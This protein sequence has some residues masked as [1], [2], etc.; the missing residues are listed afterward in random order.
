MSKET[1]DQTIT[2]FDELEQVL[3]KARQE[4][5]R[6]LALADYFFN[7]DERERFA[8]EHRFLVKV[9]LREHLFL[10]SQ[11]TSLLLLNLN[12][13]DI[14]DTG[15]GTISKLT[16]L[17]SLDLA[18]NKIGDAGTEELSKL[19]N[20]YILDLANNQIRDTG[21]ETISQLT[22]LSF[23]NLANNKIGDTGAEA[24]SKL[25]NLASLYL[26]SNQIGKDGAVALSRLSNLTSLRIDRNQIGKDGAIALSKLTNLISLGISINKIGND[27]I[28]ALSNL[29]G[30][31]SLFT[32]FN[33]I[34]NDGAIALSK[35]SNL[36][37]LDLRV[38]EIGDEGA[39]ALSKLGNLGIVDL[40]ANPI[41]NEGMQ[42][43]F[44]ALLDSDTQV[45][46]RV[47]MLGGN[48]NSPDFLTPEI[49]ESNGAQSILAAYRSYR[50]AKKKGQLKPLNEVKLL[51]VGNEAVGKTSLVRA[52]VEGKVCNDGEPTT[53]GI[54]HQK[55]ETKQWKEDSGITI[56]IWD[57]GGQEVMHGTHRFFLTSRSIYLVVLSDRLHDDRSVNDWLRTIQSRVGD[58]P[59]IVVINK[60]DQE[61][62]GLYLNESGLRKNFPSIIGFI[63]TSCIQDK[64]DTIEPLKQVIIRTIQQDERLKDIRNPLPDSWMQVKNSLV[65]KAKQ[66]KIL[67]NDEFNELCRQ[68]GTITDD[69]EQRAL[70]GLLHDLGVIVIYDE[71][72][73]QEKIKLLDPNWLTT[74]IYALINDYRIKENRGVF[75]EQMLSNIL[76]SSEYTREN[77]KYIIEMMENPTLELCFQL[78]G[79]KEYLIPEALPKDEPSTEQL[80]PWSSGAL[81][82]QCQ[83]VNDSSIPEGLLPRLIVRLHRFLIAKQPSW[84]TGAILRISRCE[85]LILGNKQKKTIDMKIAGHIQ[86]RRSSLWLVL[87]AIDDLHQHYKGLEVSKVVPLPEQPEVS[88]PYDYLLELEDEEGIEHSFKPYGAIRKYK[89]KEL[90]EGVRSL[91]KKLKP[92]RSIPEPETH[93]IDKVPFDWTGPESIELL[94]VLSQAYDK[95]ENIRFLLQRLKDIDT[96]ELNLRGSPQ[97]MWRDAIDALSRRGCLRALIEFV[98]QDQSIQGFHSAL[99]RLLEG[100]RLVKEVTISTFDHVEEQ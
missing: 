75:S 61:P 60:C 7:S 10:I 4:Q 99:R 96:S 43:L 57:F 92:E 14:G 70:R 62:Y 52:L 49:L 30:L 72:A 9:P 39:V 3:T 36:V 83:Y 15:A 12:R 48:A 68:A 95:V 18:H 67:T 2:T 32:S 69:N 35:L 77:Y 8:P 78:L 94:R 31:T 100:A 38:N 34:S 5:W 20:L 76:P 84:R 23:L 93:L 73:E 59:I 80:E 66:K 33:E 71:T 56:N 86:D 25:S 87:D 13:N 46:L 24:I 91:P 19:T 45:K 44:D 55:I 6:D 21:A 82:F 29:K 41:G 65:E 22:G 79:K 37:S 47:L 98:L 16:S 42:G 74:A 90:L 97:N 54:N 27:G 89:V 53:A 88:V 63:R 11:L 28:I 17:I 81:L 50:E 40:R 1:K 64:T 26:E 58:V 85:V 51:V